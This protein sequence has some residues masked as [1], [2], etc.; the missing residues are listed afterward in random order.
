MSTEPT[1]AERTFLDEVVCHLQQVC[2]VTFVYQVVSAGIVLVS[3]KCGHILYFDD[4]RWEP[5]AGQDITVW[6]ELS[7]D[8]SLAFLRLTTRWQTFAEAFAQ[9]TDKLAPINGDHRWPVEVEWALECIWVRPDL[10]KS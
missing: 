8:S 10:R 5:V 1:E 4:Y 9:F 7:A 3:T 6:S 2:T